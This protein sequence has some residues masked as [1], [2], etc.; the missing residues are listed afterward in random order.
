MFVIITIH[1]IY[2]ILIKEH[3]TTGYN[4]WSGW[5]LKSPFRSLLWTM[6]LKH[7]DNGYLGNVPTKTDFH[8]IIMLSTYD[9]RII[10]STCRKSL[11]WWMWLS[12]WWWNIIKFIFHSSA[13]FCTKQGNYYRFFPNFPTFF[14]F[15][16][17]S[18]LF[19]NFNYVFPADSE[20]IWLVTRFPCTHLVLLFHRIF[21]LIFEIVVAASCRR[22]TQCQF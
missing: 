21:A 18:S 17:D 22:I 5:K 16:V 20:I 7:E 13:W 8:I 9:V 3:F 2:Y 14:F 1:F 19:S 6:I 15:E 4:T 12:L 10:I 11:V